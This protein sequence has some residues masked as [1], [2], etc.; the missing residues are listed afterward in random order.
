MAD[1]TIV[2]PDLATLP[3]EIPDLQMGPPLSG[4]MEGSFSPGEWEALTGFIQ[5]ADALIEDGS[6]V[7]GDGWLKVRELYLQ[8]A[9]LELHTFCPV[10]QRAVM[11]ELNPSLRVSDLAVPGQVV[12]VACHGGSIWLDD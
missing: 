5:A 1:N 8:L 10:V 9:S 12:C 11:L 6:P 2:L 3:K 4:E 7:D